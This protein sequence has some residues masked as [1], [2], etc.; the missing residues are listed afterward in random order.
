MKT[1]HMLATPNT[2]KKTHAKALQIAVTIFMAYTDDVQFF[3]KYFWALKW[4]FHVSNHSAESYC[5][6]LQKMRHKK[7][8]GLLKNKAEQASSCTTGPRSRCQAILWHM[9]TATC[10][11]WRNWRASQIRE[12]LFQI[13]TQDNFGSP[14]CVYATNT[15]DPRATLYNRRQQQELFS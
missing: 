15:E 7:W 1:W 13:R 12:L 5:P 14:F 4:S 10:L 9:L 8:N 3:C 6:V 2:E 11:S